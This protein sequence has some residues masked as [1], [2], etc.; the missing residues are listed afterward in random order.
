MAFDIETDFNEVGS[1]S[2]KSDGGQVYSVSSDADTLGA[3]MVS[4]YLD[5][6]ATA[7]KINVEDI[8]LLSGTDGAQLVMVSTITAGVVVVSASANTGIALAVTNPS[9]IAITHRSVDV[10]SSSATPTPSLADGA[11]GQ[12]LNITLVVDDGTMTMTPANGLGYS[13]ITF[14]DAGD[15]VQLEFK[16]GGWAVIGQGGL[17]TGPVVA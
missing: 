12:L 16:S 3:M 14:A 7:G 11:I 13:T 4:G 9:A 8:I 2:N 1:A 17:S 15:S 10:T 5:A 6:L